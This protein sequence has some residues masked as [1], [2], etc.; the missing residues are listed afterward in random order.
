MSDGVVFQGIPTLSSFWEI[1]KK[2]G[3]FH[4]WFP[5][6]HKLSEVRCKIHFKNKMLSENVIMAKIMKQI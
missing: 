4:W 5:R 6:Q 1:Y 2:Y 3:Y